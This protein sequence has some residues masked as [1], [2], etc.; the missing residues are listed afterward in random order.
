MRAL[1]AALALLAIVGPAQGRDQVPAETRDNPW[2]GE[3]P[4]CDDPKVLSDVSS[5]FADKEEIYWDSSLTIAGYD[6][7][8]SV[9]YRPWGL[10]YIP[11]RFCTARAL[12]S[13]GV[14]RQ[15]YYSVRED[16]GTIGFT[17]GVEF[18]VVGLDRN[19]AYAP[20]CKMA[21]P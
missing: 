10:D 19:R 11:R 6:R 4:A 5:A 7:V 17:W 15:V 20:L 2:S 13:D 1:L 14:R 12:V 3:M 8:R 9:A 16:L 18:C 21:R